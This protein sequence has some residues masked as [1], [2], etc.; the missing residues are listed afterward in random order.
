MATAYIVRF[1]YV[2]VEFS[3]SCFL[4]LSMPNFNGTRILDLAISAPVFLRNTRM[5]CKA[6]SSVIS[7]TS[8]R[9]KLVL[10]AEVRTFYSILF[11]SSPATSSSLPFSISFSHLWCA[12]ADKS[13]H[14]ISTC[15][16]ILGLIGA[17]HSSISWI[18]LADGLGRKRRHFWPYPKTSGSGMA[19]N[20][21]NSG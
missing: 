12:L 5:K 19:T 1:P 18:R 15:H 4:G 20:K 16:K 10:P 14:W 21:L 11:Q 7:G 3:E 9:R 6:E 17:E 13:K 8:P 2:S